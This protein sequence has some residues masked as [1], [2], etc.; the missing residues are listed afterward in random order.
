MLHRLR[1]ATLGYHARVIPVGLGAAGAMALFALF[2]EWDARRFLAR[3]GWEKAADLR[4]GFLAIAMFVFLFFGN[5]L[6]SRFPRRCI[7][8][9][10]RVLYV[11][12]WCI[13][14]A[15]V[16][17]VSCCCDRMPRA[18]RYMCSL[19][20]KDL[21]LAQAEYYDVCGR[22]AV[23]TESGDH[24]TAGRWRVKVLPYSV[25]AAPTRRLKPLPCEDAEAAR[26]EDGSRGPQGTVSAV[27]PE[28]LRCPCEPGPITASSY[29][30][31]LPP[32]R[33]EADKHSLAPEHGQQEKSAHIRANEYTPRGVYPI[34]ELPGY[35]RDWRADG[36]IRFEDLC[37]VVFTQC[38][39]DN[40]CFRTH[41]HRPLAISTSGQ[42]VELTQIRDA[43][44]LFKR[45]F[46]GG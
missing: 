29:F 9:T 40:G 17:F 36:V 21:H 42:I 16:A 28:H 1:R 5:W 37:D 26:A 20:L 8:W 4:W 15:R 14:I 34:V 12:F 3:C 46:D 27:C 43:V 23:A 31:V 24:V 44:E 10:Y 32:T 38:T 6:S 45:L 13:A 7:R 35:G 19:R 41:V 33:I 11:A 22:S 30:A 2:F 39:A 18:S 25:L